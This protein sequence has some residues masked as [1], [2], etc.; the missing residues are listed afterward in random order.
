M[1]KVRGKRPLDA[2]LALLT[3]WVPA[4]CHGADDDDEVVFVEDPRQLLQ[5]AP[6]Q[7]GECL[8]RQL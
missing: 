3:T 5:K 8:H 6:G 2:A 4:F 1:C 7:P